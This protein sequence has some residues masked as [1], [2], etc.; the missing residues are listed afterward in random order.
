MAIFLILG[1]ACFNIS[2]KLLL[3]KIIPKNIPNGVTSTVPLIAAFLFSAFLPD[4]IDFLSY[5]GIISCLSNGFIYPILIK[6]IILNKK[7]Q[8]VRQIFLSLLLIV[9]IILGGVSLISLFKN[10]K[11]A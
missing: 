1:M 5:N 3:K 10:R 4:V 6:I 11:N 8:R 2:L 9:L 7:K